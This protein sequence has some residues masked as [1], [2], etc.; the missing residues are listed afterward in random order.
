MGKLTIIRHHAPDIEAQLA[1]LEYVLRLPK[2]GEDA[3]LAGG[4]IEQAQEGD[5]QPDPTGADHLPA[6]LVDA[7]EEGNEAE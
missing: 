2:R 7:V 1:A 4:A 6:T 3:L 5:A